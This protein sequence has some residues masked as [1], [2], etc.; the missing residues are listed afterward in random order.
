MSSDEPSS[1]SLNALNERLG[2][3]YPELQAVDLAGALNALRA[4][5]GSGTPPFGCHP[6]HLSSLSRYFAHYFANASTGDRW[7]SCNVSTD[8]R[9]L[10]ANFS[11]RGSPSSQLETSDL[12]V[13][14]GASLKF[15]VERADAR[16]MSQSFPGFVSSDEHQ[17]HGDSAAEEVARGWM[18]AKAGIMLFRPQMWRLADVLSQH[19]VFSKLMPGMSHFVL[20]FSRCTRY[21]HSLDGLPSV[22]LLERTAFRVELQGR[23]LGNVNEERALELLIGALPENCP[24][25]VQ[26]TAE[27][28][29]DRD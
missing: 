24:P 25:A 2:E 19:P 21:P 1:P 3:L 10:I 29:G 6:P 12:S 15:L 13:V 26:G 28:L 7:V 20:W 16:E 4:Q 22:E 5:E 14:A 27:D 9:L 8:S 23:V 17:P 11:C 18:Y